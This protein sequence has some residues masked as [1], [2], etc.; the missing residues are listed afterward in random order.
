MMALVRKLCHF[1]IS[2]RLC[3][4]VFR[5]FMLPKQH[6]PFNLHHFRPNR[7]ATALSVPS[8]YS[9]L[10]QMLCTRGQQGAFTGAG[11]RMPPDLP[12]GHTGRHSRPHA[13]TASSAYP[14]LFSELPAAAGRTGLLGLDL[15]AA[16]RDSLSSMYSRVVCGTCFS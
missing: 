14:M 11:V 4:S 13:G 1:V 15:A 8:P 16:S 5:G 10:F 7:N 6:K 2:E 9:V 12:K 3:R